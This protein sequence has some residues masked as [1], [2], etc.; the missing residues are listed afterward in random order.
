MTRH[1]LIHLIR[2]VRGNPRAVILTEFLFG[3]PYNLY[4]PY[5]SV[6]MLQLGLTDGQIGMVVSVGLASQILGALLGG[7]V[8]DKLGR[9]KTTLIFDIFAWS[10]P[11]LIWAV[12]QDFNYFIAAAVSTGCFRVA[13][14]SWNCLLVEDADPAELIDIYTWVYIAAL[15]T[16]LVAPIS[17]WLVSVF[18]LVP[19]M[20]GLY[21]FAFMVLT[22]KILLLYR[23][24]KETKQGL[25]RMAATRSQSLFSLFHG[26]GDVFRQMLRTPRT[27]FTLAIMLAMTLANTVSTTFWSILVTQKAQF[28]AEHVALFPFARSFAMLVFFFLAM[29][30]IKAMKFRNPMMVGFVL[31]AVSQII[32]ITMPERSYALLLLSTLIEACSYA[33]VS[34]QIDRMV[35]VTVDAQERARIMALLYLVVLGISTPFGW[36][37]GRLSE[38]NRNLPFLMN[39]GLYTIGVVMVFLAA[40]QHTREEAAAVPDS[41]VAAE[42]AEAVEPA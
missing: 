21:F 27:L 33:T 30:A 9:R 22:T 26:Y 17:G 2:S 24:S 31:L 8:T 12:A 3:I 34:T 5:A 15:V 11:A 23:Y 42:S 10:L 41:A 7:P 36:I 13:M 4:M 37:A 25:V 14:T 28:P 6:Y 40:R 19:A 1:P 39:I 32:L 35:V 16:G 29:P 18:S 20:R 38:I